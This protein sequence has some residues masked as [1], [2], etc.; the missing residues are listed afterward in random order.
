MPAAFYTRQPGPEVI[1]RLNEMYAAFVGGAVGGGTGTGVDLTALNAAVATAEAAAALAGTRATA[2]GTSATNAANS[3]SSVGT[4]ATNAATS[5]TNAANSAAAA[6][7]SVTAVANSATAASSAATNSATSATASANSATAAGTSATNAATSAT[8]AGTSA[9]NAANSAQSAANSASAAAVSAGT[10]PPPST[11][12]PL[13]PTNFAAAGAT[14]TTMNLSWSASGTATGYNIY[15]A[16]VKISGP[17]PIAALSYTATGLAA[18]TAYTWTVKAVNANGEGAG[19]NVS[20]STIG[21]SLPAAPLNLATTAQTGTS[22]TLGWGA[23]T[24][25][26]GYNVYMNGVKNNGAVVAGNS[27]YVV[28]GLTAA[29]TYPF[30][31]KAVNSA[32]EGPASAALNASTTGATINGLTPLFTRGLAGYF[33]A[34]RPTYSILAVSQKYGLVYV[35]NAQ[36]R[37]ATD[38]E[39]N[40]QGNRDNLGDGTFKL[41]NQGEAQISND[42]I[43]AVRARGQKVVLT[44]GGAGANYN[45]DTR[46][47]SDAF[48]ASAKVEIAKLQIPANGSAPGVDGI[49]LNFFEAFVR[50]LSKSNPSATVNF[51]TEV[52][53][54]VQTLRDFYGANFIVTMPPTPDTFRT[55]NFAP[56]DG[57]LAKALSDRGLLTC[58]SPQYY[59]YVETKTANYIKNYHVQWVAHLSG[60]QQQVGI[61]LSNH[62]TFDS[63]TVAEGMRELTAILALYP[64]TR[65]AYCWNIQA[66]M[67]AGNTWV[68]AAYTTMGVGGTAPPAEPPV[69]PPTVDESAVTNAFTFEGGKNGAWLD[70]APANLRQG[71]LKTDPVVTASGQDFRRIVDRSTNDNDAVF[72]TGPTGGVSNYTSVAGKHLGQFYAAFISQSGGGSG[73]GDTAW[74][75]AASMIV[76]PQGYYHTAWTDQTTAFNGRFLKYDPDLNGFVFSVGTGLDRKS[77][78]IGGLGTLYQ[79]PPAGTK[80]QVDL[81]HFGLTIYM[82]V[83]RGAIVSAPCPAF[84]LGSTEY[85]ISGKIAVP[86]EEGVGRINYSVHTISALTEPLCE[87]LSLFAATKK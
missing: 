25:A 9:T 15:Q 71:P 84:A 75:F 10:T 2:A 31:V 36:P 12:A 62:Q 33:E 38:G 66:D 67:D 82:R 35:F 3:A 85:A 20:A 32:G 51:V 14:G 73:Q 34:Y 77:V 64:N 59:E 83:N 61:G 81:R 54:I 41:F 4:S 27:G 26:T 44:F 19:S 18:S 43:Q 47:K 53:Y 30:T 37:G 22:I 87:N 24:G 45:F 86:G 65:M 7:S 13:A 23:V 63:P 72:V 56:L 1:Q 11:S 58:A 5:A 28:T 29:T 6:A 50:D 80:F 78:I 68:D 70:L 39:K 8:N 74:G 55:P 40:A 52:T 48:I 60:R 16:G 17:T 46:P 49:D 57:Q 42:K 76:E 79:A 21:L 69:T